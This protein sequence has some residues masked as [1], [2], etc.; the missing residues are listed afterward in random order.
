M[1]NHYYPR[2]ISHAGVK[3]PSD[4]QLSYTNQIWSSF[5]LRQHAFHEKLWNAFHFGTRCGELKHGRGVLIASQ[6]VE[7]FFFVLRNCV[8]SLFGLIKAPYTRCVENMKIFLR[9]R[10]D[11]LTSK[12]LVSIKQK[13]IVFIIFW[14]IMNRT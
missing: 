7:R 8:Y 10:T 1:L 3:P 11:E 2:Y 12:T 4:V 13:Q 9:V 5:F 14:L 6:V